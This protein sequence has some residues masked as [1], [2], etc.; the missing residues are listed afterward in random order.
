M[1]AQ[2]NPLRKTETRRWKDTI[3]IDRA[4]DMARDHALDSA[5]ILAGR[6]EV[7]IEHDGA[8]YRLRHTKNGK[9]ILTK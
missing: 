3:P 4:A 8:V 5:Q 9:L 2:L 7:I 1:S 6:R